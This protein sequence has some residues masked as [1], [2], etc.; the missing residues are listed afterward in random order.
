MLKSLTLHNFKKHRDLHVEFDGGVNGIFGPNYRG[1]TSIFHGILF[2][3]GGSSHVP[4]T[5]LQTADAE[6][7][8]SVELQLDLDG[9]S[10]KLVR[11]K[12]T[13][14]LYRLTEGEWAN[15]A[16]SATAVTDEVE[17]LIG[18]TIK[19]WKELHYAKQKSAHALLK[20]SA[21]ALHQLMRR[22]N[23]AEQLDAVVANLK[24][25][26]NRA[27]TS[28][29]AYE[30]AAGLTEGEV[31]QAK[32][33]LV[34]QRAQIGALTEQVAA[35]EE[36]KAGHVALRDEAQARVN[37]LAEGI[38]ER[39]VKQTSINQALSKVREAEAA[40]AVKSEQAIQLSASIVC[41]DAEVDPHQIAQIREKVGQIEEQDGKV[42]IARRDLA[43]AEANVKRREAALKEAEASPALGADT[44]VD[45]SREQSKADKLR[46][47]IADLQ[48]QVRTMRS[49]LADAVCPTCKRPMDEHDPEKLKAE[50][51]NCSAELH[52]ANTELEACN[53]VL[54]EAAQRE[55]AAAGAA[56]VVAA[57]KQELL[58][59]QN[60][61]EAETTRLKGAEEAVDSLFEELDALA[62]GIE[63]EWDELLAWLSDKERWISEL[64]RRRD[65]LTK[66]E[67]E[68]DAGHRELEALRKSNAEN[69][70][71]QDVVDALEREVEA[72]R[73]EREALVEK[74]PALQ[75]AVQDAAAKLEREK[76]QL[77]ELTAERRSLAERL[78][79]AEQAW[80]QVISSRKR[81][82]SIQALQ[83]YLKVNAEGFMAKAWDAFLARASNFVWQCT[84]GDISEIRRTS[85]GAF[86][87]V[88]DGME[89]QLE[90]A[91]GAQEAIIGLAVQ[92]SLAE[93]APCG[94]NLLMLDEP[95]ADMDPLRSM[96][97]ISAMGGLGRQ[98]VYVSH[99]QSDNVVTS[100]AIVF[101]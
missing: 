31:A 62:Q 73:A 24:T 21:T 59:A 52:L 27:S 29:E 1:K 66:L 82:A 47:K 90:E 2:A 78:T 43:S 92:L 22:L 64:A 19:E 86:V 91:S 84:G 81:L 89:M 58:A 76:L 3:L 34:A 70:C 45:V 41:G 60:M 42:A 17:R 97:A 69:E 99:H 5:R 88:E 49:Q 57:A 101:E 93:A 85:E 23:G 11:T 53:A 54:T 95:T 87:F 20:Y 4:G 35:C 80:E 16:T 74:L 25:M 6:G 79:S 71:T 75:Q 94:L 13:A 28:A 14:N 38:Y 50:L 33:T 96:A 18:M 63:M 44:K 9:A 37:E 100:N 98:V 83:K 39:G 12:S 72:L 40:F 77:S 46:T 51:S 10:Y 32:A 30:Q 15:V 68:L 48:A 26:A 8:M 67:A 36:A 55:K 7:R 65:E 61:A 56:A